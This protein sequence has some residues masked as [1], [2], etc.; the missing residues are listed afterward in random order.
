MS[1][2]GLRHTVWREWRR[3]V[4][5]PFH[6]LVMVGVP[7]FATLFMS[8]IFNK[9]RITNIPIGVV[10]EDFTATTRNIARAIDATPALTVV[11]HYTS[12]AEAL[13]AVRAKDIYGYVL[14]P[15][16]FEADLVGNRAPSIEYYF[17]YA[18]MS[19]GG[20][21]EATLAPLLAGVAIRPVE[22]TAAALGL[23]PQAIS[24]LVMPIQADSLALFNPSLNY[25]TYL[26]LP[27][28]MVIL[29]I[30]VLLTTIYSIG[31]EV[32]SGTAIR[33][34]IGAG[35]NIF[36]AILGKLIPYTLTFST[37]IIGSVAWLYGGVDGLPYGD[38]SLWLL[39]LW[40]VL[41][42]VSTQALGLFLY[43]LFPALGFIMSSGSMIGSLGATLCGV[44]FPVGAITP[45]FQPVASLLPIRHYTL[46]AQNILYGHYGTEWVWKNIVAMLA[47]CALSTLILPRLR[48]AILSRRYE[49][50]D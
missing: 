1:N 10:D 40:G 32:K 18:M 21:I 23:S 2:F 9:G 8:T 17:H 47:V 19:V 50:I 37:A 42:V 20:V 33:W 49:K 22:V 24:T 39:V 7:L 46:L 11:D 45:I 3:I 28:L 41:L 43:G 26:S 31:S 16:H 38:G 6:L 35:G 36:K 30:V 34:I 15:A 13:S 14:F 44:T 12:P 25:S 5:R 4:S 27:L 29:Q 48:M